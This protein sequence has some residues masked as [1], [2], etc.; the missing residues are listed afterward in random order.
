MKLI[1]TNNI[2]KVILA[3]A[4]PGDPDLVTVKTANYLQQADV[5]LTD[6]LVS[7]VI[8]D[9]YVKPSARIIEVGKQCRRGVS[10]PQQT[11]NELMVQYAQ[12]GNLVVR[13]KGGDVSFFSNVLD[14]LEVL[15]ANQIPYEMVPGV[16]AASGAA[17]YAGIPLT[18][19]NHATAVRFLTFYK[20]TVVSDTYWKELATTEDTLVFYMSS[21]TLDDLVRKLIE[22]NVARDTKL[23]VIEQ[24]TTTYQQVYV[25]NIYE[26]EARLQGQQ[27]LS[28]SLIIIGKVVSLQ[29]SF[30]WFTGSDLKE[31]YFK[32]LTS[33]VK[34]IVTN[35][36]GK[37]YAGRA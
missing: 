19:R 29:E 1:N 37:K 2:G 12:E 34:S 26:Y 5:V 22:H 15:V 3:G 18:A 35:E 27:F 13:L 24:A 28:P 10:T 33:Q 32:P 25:S 11:I 36:P 6:R 31:Y 16:T 14:E 8:L 4:G 20:S 17:A 7:K 21:E 30:G 9:R 23:A